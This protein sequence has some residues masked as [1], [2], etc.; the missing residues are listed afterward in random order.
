[1]A[2]CSEHYKQVAKSL[3]LD[4]ADLVCGHHW[5]ALRKLSQALG[6]AVEGALVHLRLATL[7]AEGFPAL[8][9]EAGRPQSPFAFST[10]AWL[11]RNRVFSFFHWWNAWR[12]TNGRLRVWV[13]CRCAFLEALRTQEVGLRTTKESVAVVAKFPSA[14]VLKLL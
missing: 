12:D 14:T 2:N 5:V 11:Y 10:S 4:L 8:A 6:A 13:S 3:G 9:K 1:M 7:G